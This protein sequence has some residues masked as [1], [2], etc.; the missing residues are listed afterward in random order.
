M[1]KIDEF[2]SIIVVNLREEL[3]NGSTIVVDDELILSTLD[4][5]GNIDD[6]I[7]TFDDS[8]GPIK[9]VDDVEICSTINEFGWTEI[10]ATLAVEEHWL[11]RHLVNEEPTDA[12]IEVSVTD[13]MIGAT[14]SVEE[15]GESRLL[16]SEADV[17]YACRIEMIRRKGLLLNDDKR[18][19][20]EVY[21]STVLSFFFFFTKTTLV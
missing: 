12:K 21:P 9:L 15:M 8:S 4:N 18:T 14:L 13:T 5:F 1:S 16:E 2:V 19:N 3:D 20:K 6:K 11:L 10:D 7:V 17:I